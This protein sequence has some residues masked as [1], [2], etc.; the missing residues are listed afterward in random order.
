LRV[1]AH[2]VAF[3]RCEARNRRKIGSHDLGTAVA[4]RR[5]MKRKSLNANSTLLWC[6][7][8]LGLALGCRD[9]PAEGPAEQAGKKVDNAAAEV[10]EEAREV[11][12]EAKEAVKSDEKK[13]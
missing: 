11:K 9:K 7:C 13:K 12:E 5:C 6:I 2:A 1:E 3:L 10:K 4:L 8:A